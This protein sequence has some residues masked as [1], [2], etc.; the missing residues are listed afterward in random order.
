MDNV[1]TEAAND[2]VDEESQLMADDMSFASGELKYMFGDEIKDIEKEADKLR[3]ENVNTPRTLVQKFLFSLMALLQAWVVWIVWFDLDYGVS[4]LRTTNQQP[5]VLQYSMLI[6]FSAVLSWISFIC[7]CVLDPKDDMYSS[8]VLGVEAANTGIGTALV[9]AL[10]DSKWGAEGNIIQLLKYL[11]QYQIFITY[12]NVAFQA[13][14][15]RPDIKLPGFIQKI[16]D[17]FEELDQRI[18]KILEPLVTFFG[19]LCSKIAA[20]LQQIWDTICYGLG[21]MLGWLEYPL[22]YIVVGVGGIIIF[23]YDILCVVFEVISW[24][25]N[26]VFIFSCMIVT[27]I[28]TAIGWMIENLMVNPVVWSWD[29]IIVFPCVTLTQWL[30]SSFGIFQMCF[31]Y[32]CFSQEGMKDTYGWLEVNT[33]THTHTHT[34]IYIYIYISTNFL[35]NYFF[36]SETFFFCTCVLFRKRV[37]LEFNGFLIFIP[38]KRV[39]SSTSSEW[40]T[41]IHQRGQK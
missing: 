2:A 9:Q 23:V 37:P 19:W 30:S 6:V 27:S 11:I 31:D 4:A 22:A 10:G 16:I 18:N 25:L 5:I 17:L 12:V 40:G 29:N 3:E 13:L 26:Q 32:F 38:L 8:V 35:L 20:P 7:S 1:V 39:C 14:L 15:S 28:F 33:H 36:F 21:Y 34:Y 24:C 41:S